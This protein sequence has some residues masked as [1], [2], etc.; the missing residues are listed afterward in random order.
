MAACSI[1]STQKVQTH[2]PSIGYLKTRGCIRRCCRLVTF[3]ITQ[4]VPITSGGHAAVS[5]QG[6]DK[7]KGL[8]GVVAAHQAGMSVEWLGADSTCIVSVR[9]LIVY[10]SSS[11]VIQN[12]KTH[13]SA[14]GHRN[15]RPTK[16]MYQ[17]GCCWRFFC[18]WCV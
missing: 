1:L 9:E 12:N 13:K 5:Q 2:A 15:H 17:Q 8:S 6:E 16:K 10:L 3:R 11:Q 18:V 7:P 14:E 4:R